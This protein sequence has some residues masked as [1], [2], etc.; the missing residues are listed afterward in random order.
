MANNSNRRSRSRAARAEAESSGRRYMDAARALDAEEPLSRPSAQGRRAAAALVG[1]WG[2]GDVSD[3]AQRPAGSGHDAFGPLD[4]V[5]PD[6]EVPGFHA[7]EGACLCGTGRAACRQCGAPA[8]FLVVQWG[9]TSTCQVQFA[10]TAPPAK[11]GS[12]GQNPS[13]HCHWPVCGGVCADA[14]V[15]AARGTVGAAPRYYRHEALPQPGG[16]RPAPVDV[17][18]LRVAAETAGLLASSVHQAVVDGDLR[19]AA[20]DVQALRRWLAAGAYAAAALDLVRVRSVR[21]EAGE[22]APSG[23]VVVVACDGVEYTRSATS[24]DLWVGTALGRGTTWDEMTALGTVFVPEHT[25][26]A[27]PAGEVRRQLV[28][29][30]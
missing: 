30:R 20:E 22:P 14:V 12:S 13:D 15:D 2:D 4:D 29:R 26:L 10:P 19:R 9:V 18:R 17:A 25:V 16:S 11:G 27:V 28:E 24:P 6:A 8:R 21:C 7:A 3:S 23:A 1:V 5:S